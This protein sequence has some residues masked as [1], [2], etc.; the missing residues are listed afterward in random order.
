MTLKH[1]ALLYKLKQSTHHSGAADPT[2]GPTT[3]PSE[4]QDPGL[5]GPWLCLQVLEGEPDTRGAQSGPPTGPSPPR[6]QA[7]ARVR[8]G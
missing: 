5:P 4:R 2:T 1:A 7:L 8:Q 6:A 3:G